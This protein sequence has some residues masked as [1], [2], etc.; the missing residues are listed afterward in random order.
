MGIVY[1]PAMAPLQLGMGGYLA[2]A[3]VDAHD[4]V[5]DGDANTLADHRARWAGR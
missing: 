1:D 4:L 2:S 3:M 5:A